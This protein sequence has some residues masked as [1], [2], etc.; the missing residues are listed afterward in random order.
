[1][2]RA[3]AFLLLSLLVTSWAGA[4]KVRY[5]SIKKIK[6]R[7]A[8]TLVPRDAPVS[9][10]F[11]RP[12]DPATVTPANVFIQTLDGAKVPV[13]YGEEREGRTVVL[14]PQAL[15][16]AGTDY[17]IVVRDA[18]RSF[19]GRALRRERRSNFFTDPR[20]PA[21][22]IL[23]P[24]QFSPAASPMSEQ[25]GGHSATLLADG[26]VLLAGGMTDAA[27][28][29]V[30]GD[31]FN[32]ATNEFRSSGGSL[33]VPRTNHVA[34]VHGAGILLIGGS[35]A[36]G[37]LGST[38]LFTPATATYREGPPLVESRD[39]L[40]ALTLPDGRVFVT[41]GVYVSGG[42][43]FYRQ[44]A[45]IF[46]PVLQEFR[47]TAFAPAGRRAAHTMTLLTDGTVFITG[48]QSSIVAPTAEIFDPS[49]ETFTSLSMGTFGSRQLPPRRCS[50][51]AGACSWPTAARPCS[52]CSTV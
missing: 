22:E 12:L 46:D 4:A 36:N 48:G 40:A 17:Q 3:I 11:S 45:E 10:R 30:S 25:R 50:Q 41:G 34:A 28:F 33:R 37:P 39:F 7:H 32:P 27:N 1:M 6:P 8:K 35:D 38:E 5:V 42:K 51:T 49:T 52:T 14:T 44:T 29:A 18:V 2:R 26:R 24:S 47:L 15:L 20:S 43:T 9:I 13:T 21:Q 16:D 19:D 31:V 23:R